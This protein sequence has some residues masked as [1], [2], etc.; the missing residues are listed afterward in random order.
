M[1]S[2]YTYDDVALIHHKYYSKP[3]K[4]IR[5]SEKEDNDCLTV[6]DFVFEFA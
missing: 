5:L 4:N 3:I 2:L 6:V 1:K